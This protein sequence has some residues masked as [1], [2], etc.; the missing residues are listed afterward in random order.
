MDVRIQSIPARITLISSDLPVIVDLYGPNMQLLLALT[1]LS[2]PLA[3]SI[4]YS[5]LL[6]QRDSTPSDSM[7]I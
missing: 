5:T 4:D 7:I 1:S 3:V 2:L 6:A